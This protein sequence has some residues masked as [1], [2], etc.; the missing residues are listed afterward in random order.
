MLQVAFHG[1]ETVKFGDGHARSLAPQAANHGRQAAGQTGQPE[2]VQ[3]RQVASGAEKGK[4]LT[5]ALQKT[6][7][8]VRR[9][10]SEIGA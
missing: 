2:D 7:D 8:V 10:V 3:K 1:A 9:E 4:I 6:V 5:G